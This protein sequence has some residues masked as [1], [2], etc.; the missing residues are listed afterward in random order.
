[1][2]TL[3]WP[4]HRPANM[5]IS[6]TSELPPSSNG[7]HKQSSYSQFLWLLLTL[8]VLGKLQT[9]NCNY[10]ANISSS[11]HVRITFQPS[12]LPTYVPTYQPTNPPTYQLTNLPNLP[13]YQP[14]NPPTYQLTKPTNLP[15]YQTY[16]PTNL[17]A[18]Q[19]AT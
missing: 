15:T 9:V 12:N 7:H 10:Q 16:Q 17:R 3:Y 1:M 8:T 2:T 11:H 19:Q 14:T 6:L 18:Y 4:H 5:E 13:T